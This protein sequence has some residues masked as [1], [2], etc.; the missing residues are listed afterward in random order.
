MKNKAK[1]FNLFEPSN[2]IGDERQREYE[3]KNGLIATRLYFVLLI[4]IVLTISLILRLTLEI[5][6]I[7][8][9]KPTRSDYENLLL[10]PEAKSLNCRCTNIAVLYNQTMQ[11]NPSYHP[12]CRSDYSSKWRWL[13]VVDAL[14]FYEAN[15]DITRRFIPQ[16]LLVER[17]CLMS[18]KTITN[19]LNEFYGTS[20]V[21]TQ[22]LSI[23]LL[24]S[25]VQSLI[26]VFTANLADNFLLTVD[27]ISMV[28]QNNELLSADFTNSEV[29]ASAP[30][31]MKASSRPVMYDNCS[32]NSFNPSSCA[33]T[34]ALISGSL[35]QSNRIIEPV[36][37]LMASCYNIESVRKSHLAVFFNQTAINT[38][39][40]KKA[41]VPHSMD[42]IEAL[43]ISEL[44]TNH[45][46]NTS[47]GD[48]LADLFVEDWHLQ[49][50]FNE[51]YDACAPELCSYQIS[52][53]HSYLYIASFILGLIGGLATVLRF[54]VLFFVRFLRRK[55]KPHRLVPG[56]IDLFLKKMTN[57][58]FY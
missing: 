54:P 9:E 39:V 43:N 13:T 18:Q 11:L 23:D 34:I 22:L 20:L 4:S 5:K 45:Q 2:D 40:A 26:N 16:M 55:A 12:I 17:L 6:R 15:F 56:N 32:C 28:I 25:Q 24:T 38:I 58:E 19:G 47:I 50:T 41:H 8:V 21:S 1:R 35:E 3:L 44:S 51:Y 7:S 30:D 33:T 48:I 53:T 57:F 42:L 52:V 46:I 27:I 14:S 10:I 49:V 37:G 31:V 36:D 29:F